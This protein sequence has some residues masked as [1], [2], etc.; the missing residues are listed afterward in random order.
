MAIERFADT[1]IP[2]CDMCG[3]ELPEEYSFEDAVDSKRQNGWKSAKDASGEWW[4][5]CPECN[6]KHASRLRGIG[7]SEFGGIT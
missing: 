5:L 4:D 1:F 2:T 3:V 6:A 7:P